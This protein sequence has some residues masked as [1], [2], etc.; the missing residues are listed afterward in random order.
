M[1]RGS[2]RAETGGTRIRT[3][4]DG[5]RTHWRGWAVREVGPTTLLEEL[6]PAS[7]GSGISMDLVHPASRRRHMTMPGCT[8]ASATCTWPADDGSCLA[9][10]GDHRRRAPRPALAQRF[11]WQMLLTVVI[12]LG[13][14]FAFGIAGWEAGLHNPRGRGG[15]RRSS[16]AGI[17]LSS[18]RP[19]ATPFP[20]TRSH[21][22]ILRDDHLGLQSLRLGARRDVV[23]VKHD[24]CVAHR[25]PR[26]SGTRYG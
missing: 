25:A 7:L 11:A 2:L 17:A 20:W 12:S 10:A 13:R 18:C 16:H 15:S 6:Q 19:S 23:L 21:T 26:Q 22:A 3:S 14:S 4:P 24:H 9:M 1:R 5:C 8:T